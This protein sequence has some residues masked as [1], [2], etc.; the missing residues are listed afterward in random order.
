MDNQEFI[1]PAHYPTVKYAIQY[2][3]ACGM[4][5]MVDVNRTAPRNYCSPC[6]WAKLGE[7][8]YVI[9]S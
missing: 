1:T 4:D 8:N 9:H 7:T 5:I 6:A 2:C 3:H